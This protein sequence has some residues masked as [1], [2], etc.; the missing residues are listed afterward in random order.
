ML[1]TPATDTTP[2]MCE[3]NLILWEV[4]LSF[5]GNIRKYEPFRT[6]KYGWGGSGDRNRTAWK[7]T[8]ADPNVFFVDESVCVAGDSRGWGG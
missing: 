4:I 8:V 2:V 1:I 7:I 6:S 3:I 5:V